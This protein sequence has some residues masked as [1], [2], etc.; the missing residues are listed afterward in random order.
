MLSAPRTARLQFEIKNNV[1]LFCKLQNLFQRGNP[2]TRKL[3]AEPR[4]GIQLPQIRQ[5]EF[6]DRALS[7]GR[8]I[9]RSIMNRYEARIAGKVQVGLNES[10]AHGHGLPKRGNGILGRVSRSPANTIA[11][12]RKAVAMGMTF[13]ET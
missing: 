6:V 2:L 8:A 12:F 7:V 11:A 3:A 13:I 1:V 10:H 9:E 4:T 5:C